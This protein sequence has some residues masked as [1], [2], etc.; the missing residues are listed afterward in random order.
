MRSNKKEIEARALAYARKTGAP[1]PLGEIPGEEPD[2]RIPTGEG[3]L[4]LEISELVRPASGGSDILPI[5]AANHHES[6]IELAREIYYS[7]P[8]AK[9]ASVRYSFSDSRV[10]RRK[11]RE[12]A[13]VLA[14]FVKANLHRANPV[15]NMSR[16]EMPKGFEFDSISITSETGVWS[17]SQCGGVTLDQIPEQL[18]CRI[19]AKNKLVPTYRK[20]L[21]ENSPVWLLLYSTV[22]IAGHVPVPSCINEWK[23]KFDF[24]RVFWL[25]CL[26]SRTVEIQR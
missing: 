21:P 8:D 19:A 11:K 26:E 13:L 4:G 3:T 17:S 12:M 1:I 20:N 10:V 14:D 2:F 23:F 22:T 15:V 24:D 9:P 7:Q 18:A 16:F 5:E 6:V 25:N